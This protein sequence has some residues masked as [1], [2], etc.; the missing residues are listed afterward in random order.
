MISAVKTAL[1]RDIPVEDKEGAGGEGRGNV[2][3]RLLSLHMVTS[4]TAS[5][6]SGKRWCQRE[7]QG[8]DPPRP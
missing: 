8:L 6:V 5:V 2:L 1:G 7:T 3:L 4:G